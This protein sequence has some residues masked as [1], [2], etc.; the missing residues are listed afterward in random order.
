MK[1]N[2]RKREIRL[3]IHP[4]ET[5]KKDSEISDDFRSKNSPEN[6]SEA[7]HENK[8]NRTETRPLGKETAKSPMVQI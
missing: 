7:D 1:R 3:K 2:P 5:V 8:T 6:K 4:L